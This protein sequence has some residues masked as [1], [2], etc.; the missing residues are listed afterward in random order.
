VKHLGYE[1]AEIKIA[2]NRSMAANAKSVMAAAAAKCG[3]GEMLAKKAAS[4]GNCG[5]AG[6]WQAEICRL[7]KRNRSVRRRKARKWLMAGGRQ[8]KTI[9]ATGNEEN[10]ENIQRK[11]RIENRKYGGISHQQ[12][13]AYG[14]VMKT[15]NII[16]TGESDN[17]AI[18]TSVSRKQWWRRNQLRRK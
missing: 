11:K 13:A 9:P 3:G 8:L 4:I 7:K 1:E 6:G 5:G 10:G 18:I 2:I 16:I 17:L 12:S 14:G 15:G